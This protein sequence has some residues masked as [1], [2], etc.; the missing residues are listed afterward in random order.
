MQ[1][2]SPRLIWVYQEIPQ[3]LQDPPEATFKSCHSTPCMCSTKMHK[4]VMS[5]LATWLSLGSSPL[6]TLP[7]IIGGEKH[8][9][10]ICHMMGVSWAHSVIFKKDKCAVKASTTNFLRYINDAEEVQP[11][12]EV[13]IIYDMAWPMNTSQLME[14]WGRLWTLHHSLP[15]C[16]H[17]LPH[18]TSCCA[19]MLIPPHTWLPLN[20]KD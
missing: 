1:Y 5:E 6:W 17:I 10:I 2:Q 7:G 19:R 3:N 4:Q 13:I 9:I 12:P 18:C 15:N 16:S 8:D 14:F 20:F 11:N